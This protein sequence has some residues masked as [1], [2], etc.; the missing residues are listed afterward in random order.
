M[1]ALKV[2]LVLIVLLAAVCRLAGSEQDALAISENIRLYHMPYGTILDPVFA[3]GATRQIVGYSR[4]GD[5][6]I[7][8]GHYLAAEAFRYN[9]TRSPDALDNVRAAL[10]GLRSLA[11]VTGTDLLARCLVPAS[12]PYAT[13]ITQSEGQLGIHPAI[14]NNIPHYWIGNTSCDQYCGVF[15]GLGVA[16]DMVD[17]PLVRSEISALGTRLLDFLI[18]NGW[19]VKMPDG[20]AST[21]FLARPDQRLTLL[22]VGR[23]LNP[24]RFSTTYGLYR[25]LQAGSVST[26]VAI[27]VLDDHGS[28]FKFNLNTINLYN[29][30][31]LEGSSSRSFYDQAYD[32][33]R[34]TLDDHG[35]AHFNVID[36]A[37][38]GP[39]TARDAATRSYLRDWLLRPRRDP[40]VDWRGRFPACGADRACAP[41]PILDRVRTDFLWQRSP[42][43]LYGG[44]EGTIE[45]AGIDYILP[46]WMGRFYGVISADPQPPVALSVTPSDGRGSNAMFSFN[47]WDPNGYTDVTVALVVVSPAL[48][49]NKCCYLYYDRGQRSIWLMN[50]AGNAWFG[51]SK[52]GAGTLLQNGQCIV[53]ASGSSNSGA[54]ETLMLNLSASF[55]AGSGLKNIYLYAQDAAGLSTDGWRHLGTWTA[56]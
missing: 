7:W 20:S 21:S 25:F 45:G 10:R 32:L 42:F 52:L 43:L 27:D 2:P 3:D 24:D 44:A 41:I 50:D 34:R 29:L 47:I 6:A 35:N 37:L 12:S 4:C 8:T 39:D 1:P 56:P 30:I 55:P 11:D 17:D 54:G 22:Q 13:G 36:R 51:P 40:Y 5:S 19:I 28:Y 38:R 9:V 46:Y 26:P 18:Q 53:D 14:L 48:S 23:R 33:M 16:F 49:P 31:R 15:F